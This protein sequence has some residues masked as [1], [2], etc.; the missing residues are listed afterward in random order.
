MDHEQILSVCSGIGGLDL[1][2]SDGLRSVGGNP[3]TVCMVEREAFAVACLVKAMRNAQ[4]DEAPIWLGDVRDLP[5]EQLPDV[6]WIVGGYPCQ[7]F[8]AIGR[9]LGE[10]D[11]RHIWPAILELVRTLRPGGVFFEN[12]AGHMSLGLD[13]V[14][15]DLQ[16]C[17]FDSAFGLFS[18][19]EV[20]APHRRERVFI[21]GVADGGFERLE[22]HAGDV[23]RSR[24]SEGREDGSTPPCRLRRGRWRCVLFA[25]ELEGD[26]EDGTGFCPCFLPYVDADGFGEECCAPG[27]S[28]DGFEFR[29]FDGRLFA[30]SDR[31]PARAG[32]PPFDWEPPRTLEPRVGG[33]FHGIRDRLDRLRALGNAVVPAQAEKAFRVLFEALREGRHA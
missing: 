18:A 22:G 8:S 3:R 2:F 4:L 32:E 27:P 26:R 6:D 20:G 10:A 19:E 14:L 7:P 30:R 12:V 9:R 17:G 28:E 16:G 23:E 25:D 33:D 1:G 11:P 31:W 13:Q 29:E 24:R 5:V 21:M 15:S